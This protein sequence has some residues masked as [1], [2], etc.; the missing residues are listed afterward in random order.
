MIRI[1]LNNSK[2]LV[3]FDS[4]MTWNVQSKMTGSGKSSLD[5]INAF[6]KSTFAVCSHNSTNICKC[7][8]KFYH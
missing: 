7:F 8:E 2:P 5:F 3:Y 1:I 6:M 4:F